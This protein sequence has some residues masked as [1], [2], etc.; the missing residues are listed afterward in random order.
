MKKRILSIVFAICLVLSCVPITVFAAGAGNPY[1]YKEGTAGAAESESPASLIDGNTGTK[2]CVTG[3]SSAYIIF[4]TS[5]AVNVSGYSITTGN[6]NAENKGRNPKNWKLYGCND[7]TGSGTGTW[8]EI[9]SVTNDIVLKDEN[10]TTYNFAFDKTETAY[11]YYMLKITA[12]QSGDVMQM[13]EFELTSCDHNW[14]EPVTTSPTCTSAGYTTRNCSVCDGIDYVYLKPVDHDF[15]ESGAC[16]Y[17]HYTKEALSQGYVDEYGISR[18]LNENTTEITASSTELS[19]GWYI[20]RN[21]VSIEGNVAISGDVNLILADG[22]NLTVNGDITGGSLTI[23]GQANGTGNL[24]VGGSITGGNGLNGGYNPDYPI[25]GGHGGGITINGGTIN[26]VRIASGDGGNG[27]YWGN[28]GKG[29][30]ITIRGGK[31]KADRIAGGNGGNGGVVEADRV[32]D[33]GNGGNITISGGIVEADSITSGNGGS[34]KSSDDA[35]GLGKHGKNGAKGIIDINGGIVFQG[36]S[37]QVYGTSVTLGQSFTIS[38]GTTLTI[39]S[40][41]T[42]IIPDGVTL[43]NNGTIINSG[44]I[45]VDGTFTGTADNLYYPLT[46]VNAT[47]SGDTSEYNSKN[48][49]KAGSTI[50]LSAEP[51][52]GKIIIW[53]SSPEVDIN[54]NSFTMPA[55]A[56]TVT[57]QYIEDI[58]KPVISGIEDGKTYCAAQTVT[59]SDNDAIAT[60]MVNGTEVNLDANKQFT[61]PA[62]GEQTIV[63]TDKAGNETSVT[64]TVN[65]GHTAGNDDGNCSTPVYCIYH[66][67]TVVIV[68]KTHDFSGDWNKDAT[69]HWHIC[70]N[71]GCTV[72]DTPIPHSGTDEGD[73][74]T[75][76]ICECG[77]TIKAANA[78]H[79]YS[80]WKSN[81]N[82]TH[83]HRCTVVGCSGY[84]DGNCDGGEASY[85]NK[86]VC[87]T[88]HAEYGALRTDSTA[89]TGEIAVGT[90][91]WNSFLNT[92]T[93][94]L[95]FKDTQS[96][97]ITATDDSYN[98]DGYT[99]DKAVK[100]EY[101]LYSG[102]TALTQADLAD[103]EFTEYSRAFNINPD[104]KYVIY[105]KLTDHAS[106]V[107]YISSEGVVL[108]ASA[109]VISGVE[110]GK[111]YCEAQTVTVTEEY[112]ESV[113][114]NGTAVTL[115]A[116]NQF[117]LN[118]AEGTQTIVATDKAGNVS[119]EITVT[120]NDGHTYEW[121]SENGQYWKKCQ[122]CDDETAKKDIPTITING[123]DAVCVTQDYKFSFTLPEGATD[124]VYGYELENKG[125]LGLPAIIE[126]NEPHGVVSMEWYEP[127]ENSFKVYA[128]AKTADGFE[129]FV[130]KT[131]A[132]KSEHTDAAPKDHICDICG[133]TLSEHTGGEATCV[134][135][136]ICEYCGEE[137]GELDS[138]NHN[139]ENIPAKDA[140]VTETGNKEYWHCTDCGKYFAD[141]N[142][143][144]EIELADTVIAK[145]PPEI[146]EGMGQSLTEGESK[147]LT[148]RSNAAFGDFLRVE[149][150]GKT[151]DEKNYTV[152]EGSTV[153]T[154]KADYVATLSAGE[155]TI[156]IVSES[157]TATTT[158]IVN[159][160]AV[161]DN[162]TKSPQTGD[163]SHM[164]L[165]I[166]LLA[167]SVFGLA[168]T[169]VYSKRK[170]VR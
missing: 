150:D 118:P 93:F 30:S 152:K 5:S 170:R 35:I 39:D 122:Y 142:G 80:A 147:E 17:C 29:G 134:G 25:S 167:A 2:W 169:A 161:V 94:G 40:G 121:Q 73:C 96:V 119:A 125:D 111:T 154:L 74:T 141:E 68:A 64:V 23:Y 159:E 70:Q 163:N 58:T 22:C 53:D 56:L 139:L 32:T 60:V 92:I 114:V 15:T 66:P 145:L 24:I 81:G 126:N 157:G 95:F 110:N 112:I 55:A 120:V 165:W 101:Y 28:G 52:V 36:N 47:A 9:H 135:K 11:Q 127:S 38:T 151:L 138:T 19:G 41:K 79:S 85:F 12:V 106:N 137:Y 102:D 61:L 31:V 71:E 48:Y 14:G 57:A 86:A 158:F 49:G 156:G 26:A 166:A 21:N 1:I 105:A 46:L 153:V 160:K 99:D 113:K 62:N 63:A 104:N 90:N 16:I 97:T 13:S 146:I 51:Q 83:T 115:D 4:E 107:T 164:A 123:A 43:T 84:E 88:C 91:K 132:L 7:Y 128:G 8:E 75:A 67:D 131:V 117:T 20:V 50:E 27:G 10:N 65:N 6:D 133:A 37:G 168:G 130:S 78:E 76:V 33:G 155:H 59:V 72:T 140:T 109:P 98:H 108:D 82:G 148:F 44:K 136:A 100:V 42:L 116:N 18:T 3:F 162:D 45:Y 124:A 77:Y 89:P 103:K 129:F 144:N 87:D 34:G 69:N 149:L 54:D 143:E